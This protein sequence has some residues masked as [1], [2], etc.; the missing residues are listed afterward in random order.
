M[1]ISRSSADVPTLGPQPTMAWPGRLALARSAEAGRGR[2]ALGTLRSLIRAGFRR[3]RRLSPRS[4]P[5]LLVQAAAE[6][7]LGVKRLSWRR[8]PSLHACVLFEAPRGQDDAR[9]QWS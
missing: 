3:I 2:R 1:P 5:A 7:L 9:T 8:P 4:K 6:C